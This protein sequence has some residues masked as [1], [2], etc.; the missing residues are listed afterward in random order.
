MLTAP[1]IIPAAAH[2]AK[3]SFVAEFVR[4]PP[5]NKRNSYEFRYLKLVRRVDRCVCSG[6]A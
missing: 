3:S 1:A 6:P 2:A 4:I 5:S